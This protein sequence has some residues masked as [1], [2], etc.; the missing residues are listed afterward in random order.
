[1]RLYYLSRKYSSEEITVLSRQKSEKRYLPP[2]SGVSLRLDTHGSPGERLRLKYLTHFI[3]IPA[4]VCSLN[5][6]C[7]PWSLVDYRFC[8][9]SLLLSITML[10]RSFSCGRSPSL[11]TLP[12]DAD[13]RLVAKPRHQSTLIT[14]KCFPLHQMR[15]FSS[16]LQRGS[17]LVAVF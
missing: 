2:G 10:V 12:F 14:T 17:R 5:H 13:H 15:P 16:L 11:P 6:F 9:P 7:F 1:M 3:F 4:V 8:P